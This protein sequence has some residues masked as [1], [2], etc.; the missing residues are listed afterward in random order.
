MAQIR[1]AN[2]FFTG[3]KLSNVPSTVRYKRKLYVQKLK[4]E[5]SQIY[6]MFK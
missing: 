5:L 4:D 6:H 3:A 1:R 2:V